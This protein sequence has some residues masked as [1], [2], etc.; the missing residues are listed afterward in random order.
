MSASISFVL[1]LCR[2]GTAALC[3]LFIP[4]AWTQAGKGYEPQQRTT[5][6]V[7]VDLVLLD[8][9]V[10][11]RAG[12]PVRDLQKEHF[13]VYE[14]KIEQSISFVGREEAPVSWGLI[15]DSSGSMK[16]MMHDVYEA[17]AHVMEEGT[18]EDEMFVMTFNDGVDLV[19]ELTSDRRKLQQSIFGLQ[20]HGSTALY[21]AVASALDHIKQGKHRKKVLVVITDGEDNHSSFSFRRLLDRVRESDVLIYTVGMRVAMGAF[22]SL[23]ESR[24]DLEEMAKITGGYAYFP[25]NIEKCR[26]T[27]SKIAEEVSEHYTIG[28]YPANREHDGRLRKI[29]IAIA[30]SEGKNRKYTVRARSGYYAPEVEP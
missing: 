13:K 5:L 11:D 27:M 14:D 3:L 19:L 30:E 18:H 10:Q 17:A 25:T 20:S 28:Y 8:V 16:G 26:Q 9:T 22:R 12:Q 6:R 7:G 2:F 15:L 4:G 1:N 21:D 23:N 29:K 24:H